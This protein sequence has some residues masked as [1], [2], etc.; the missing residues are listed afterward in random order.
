ML[1]RFPRQSSLGASAHE[2]SSELAAAAG[3]PVRANAAKLAGSGGGSK[4]VFQERRPLQCCAALTLTLTLTL[5]LAAQ[6]M[7][8]RK[9]AANS[10]PP[11]RTRVRVESRER[12]RELIGNCL[13]LY[14][15]FDWRRKFAGGRSVRLVFGC[16]WQ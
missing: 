1:A 14:V 11:K 16:R 5:T 3:K 4:F 6:P 9:A 7:L 2:Q 12:A 10:A 8:V 13:I 15:H